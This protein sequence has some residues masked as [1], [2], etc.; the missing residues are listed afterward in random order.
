MHV[1]QKSL[2]QIIFKDKKKR[3]F[4]FFFFFSDQTEL[5]PSDASALYK[6]ITCADENQY[7]NGD[8]VS[9]DK[10]R[11]FVQVFSSANVGAGN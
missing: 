7:K 10:I 3:I 2:A 8:F 4:H 11:P 1:L 6:L 5:L 9:G